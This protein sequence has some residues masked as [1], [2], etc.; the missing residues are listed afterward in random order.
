MGESTSG[1]IATSVSSSRKGKGVHQFAQQAGKL[2][3][4]L[5]V[6]NNRSGGDPDNL[7]QTCTTSKLDKDPNIHRDCSAGPQKQKSARRRSSQRQSMV[8]RVRRNLGRAPL[9]CTRCAYCLRP[10]RDTC[11]SYEGYTA[12]PEIDT[13]S[14][15]EHLAE[16]W[17]VFWPLPGS[18]SSIQRRRSDA[19]ASLSAVAILLDVR[20]ALSRDRRRF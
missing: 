20:L 12:T 15:F 19:T 6:G 18:F 7:L 10:V 17:P 3:S 11:D 4:Q 13:P 8:N 16:L 5:Y 9:K 1:C 2:R 14:A